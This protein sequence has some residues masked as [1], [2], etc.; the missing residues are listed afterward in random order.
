MKLY[1][2]PGSCSLSPHIVLREAGMD[3]QLER[4]D[5]KT[6][7]TE[8]G[9]DFTAVNDKSAVPCLDLGNGEVLTEGAVIVQYIA[10]Q[11]PGSKLAPANGT[12]AR[13][14]VQEWLNYIATEIHKSFTPLWRADAYGEQGVAAA[15]AKLKSCFAYVD[16]RLAQA[17]P[18]LAGGD[19]TVADAYLFT[20]LNW[21]PLKG[22]ALAEWPALSAYH[23]LVAQRPAVRSA[24]IAEGLLQEAA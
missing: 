21:A 5:L 10:D 15:R 13:A 9:A 17:G 22:I 7:T 20:V 18:Y 4:V 2:S 3:F 1:Y 8:T 16:G 14:R 12:L 11:K 6:K 24:M 23:A 19:F